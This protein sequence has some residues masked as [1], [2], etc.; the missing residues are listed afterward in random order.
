FKGI[1]DRYGHDAG[2]RVLERIAQVIAANARS[3]DFAFRYGGEEFLLV[4]VEQTES[5]AL[6]TAETLRRHIGAEVI[7]LANHGD[8]SVTAS[9]GVA[10]H[11]GHPDYQR[12]INR[13]DEALYRA[14]NE[15]RNRCMMAA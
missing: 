9:V 6:Q 3:G 2:D 7:Q 5:E 8:I 12:L 1:N 14:K 10:I 15:G 13:A 4:C 11:D